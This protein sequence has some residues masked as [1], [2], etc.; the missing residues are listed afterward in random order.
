MKWWG[1]LLTVGAVVGIGVGTRTAFAAAR[2]EEEGDDKEDDEKAEAEAEAE[3]GEDKLAERVYVKDYSSL[4][5]SD[6]RLVTVPKELSYKG[7]TRRVHKAILADLVNMLEAAKA[8]GIDPLTVSS[9]WRPRAYPDFET[10]KAAMIKRY[11]SL[12]EGRKW[13]AYE[14]PHETGLT[15]DLRN[16][17]IAAVSKTAAKQKTT[18]TFRWLKDNAADY[19]FVFYTKKGE[20]VEPWHLEHPVPREVFDAA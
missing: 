20:V 12:A 6:K 10:Y 8:A 17:D 7:A 5:S 15:V 9:G 13:K 3:T 1:W 14:S 16:K 18:P 2:R 19:G 4:L 11:G